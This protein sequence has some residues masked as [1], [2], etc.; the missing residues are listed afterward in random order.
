MSTL[1][2]ALPAQPPSAELRDLITKRGSTS[3]RKELEGN[4]KELEKKELEKELEDTDV[5]EGRYVNYV[6]FG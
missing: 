6:E 3:S 1:F 4:S 2:S 5:A